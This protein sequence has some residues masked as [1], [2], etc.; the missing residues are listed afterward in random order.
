MRK[1]LE[2]G[3]ICGCALFLSSTANS[4]TIYL[5]SSEKVSGKIVA[6]SAKSTMIQTESGAYQSYSADEIKEIKK[7]D[8]VETPVAN[9]AEKPS[10]SNNN[11]EK[12]DKLFYPYENPYMIKFKSGSSLKISLP[13]EWRRFGIGIEDGVMFIIGDDIKHKTANMT[14]TGLY[15]K[16]H[17]VYNTNE[18]R[19]KFLESWESFVEKQAG[20]DKLKNESKEYS[21]ICGVP[22]LIITMP[23][24]Q[25][26]AIHFLKGPTFYVIT[27]K[28]NSRDIFDKEWPVVEQSLKTMEIQEIKQESIAEESIIQTATKQNMAGENKTIVKLKEGTFKISLPE[29]YAPVGKELDVEMLFIKS[30]KNNAEKPYPFFGIEIIP[31]DRE[32]LKKDPL[33]AL[34]SIKKSGSPWPYEDSEI[35]GQPCLISTHPPSSSGNQLRALCFVKNGKLY[36]IKFFC[37]VENFDKEWASVEKSIKSMEFING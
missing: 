31:I 27:F 29:G 8:V 17:E 6:Q 19:R 37:K 4:E 21:E 15:D 7:E 5:K 26:K 33:K 3:V 14:I 22:S 12:T 32:D 11:K 20:P 35:F 30:G 10:V 18:L 36:S 28:A 16:K 1:W 9:I 34:E 25:Y 23:D 13:Q 2:M 24:L